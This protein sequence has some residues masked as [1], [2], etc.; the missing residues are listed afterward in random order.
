MFF[1]VVYCLFTVIYW[2]A[3]GTNHI[4]KGRYIYKVIDYSNNP[5]LAVGLFIGCLLVGA[6]LVQLILYGLYR[7]RVYI[8]R[9]HGLKH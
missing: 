8:A 7:L 3:G 4:D 1:I 2:A 9:N 6:P 5:G